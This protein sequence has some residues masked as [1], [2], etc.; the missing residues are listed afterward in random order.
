[1][2]RKSPQFPTQVSITWDNDNE[3]WFLLAWKN[4]A[5]AL[6]ED[7][8]EVATYSLARVRRGQL[9]PKFEK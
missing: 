7:P 4:P 6:S 2:K 3:E 9:V 8:R 5:D 1:M